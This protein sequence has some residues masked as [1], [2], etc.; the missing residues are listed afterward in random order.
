MHISRYTH[1][2]S[3]SQVRARQTFTQVHHMHNAKPPPHPPS[4]QMWSASFAFSNLIMCIPCTAPRL[5]NDTI[6]ATSASWHSHPIPPTK[7]PTRIL[8]AWS[9]L[10]NILSPQCRQAGKQAFHFPFPILAR[11]S[12]ATIAEVLINYRSPMS[13][14]PHRRG[15]NKAKWGDSLSIQSFGQSV[16]PVAIEPSI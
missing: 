2:I 7:S 13:Y 12:I 5:P 16:Q 10:P 15:G 6:E 3:T 4:D 8:M 9:L 14:R 11:T 1:V